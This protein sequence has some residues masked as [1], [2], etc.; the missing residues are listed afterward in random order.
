MGAFVDLTGKRFGRLVAVSKTKLRNR[1]H[2]IVWVFKCDC[3]ATTQKANKDVVSGNTQSCGCLDREHRANHIKKMS[4]HQKS[5][6]PTYQ[7]WS[8]MKK[9][10]RNKNHWAHKK[11]YGGRGIDY[12]PEW[13]KFESFLSDMGERPGDLTLDRIDNNKGYSKENCRWTTRKEQ[14]KN[15]SNTVFFE[16]NGTSKT[17]SEWSEVLNINV[18]TLRDRIKFGRQFDGPLQKGSKRA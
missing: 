14:T 10:C 17:V 18:A 11:Y 15:R 8:D 7:I 6:T 12:C 3:G 2:R 5:H 13:E 16:M 4:T 1:D 9:R